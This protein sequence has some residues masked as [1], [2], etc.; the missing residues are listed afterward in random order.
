MTVI[1]DSPGAYSVAQIAL[2][3]GAVGS[4]AIAVDAA[5]PLPVT[6]SSAPLPAGAATAANQ[7]TGNTSL[8]SIDTRL[9]GTVSTDTVVRASATDR[10]AV[11][12]TANTAQQLMAANSARRG[13]AIQN[14]SSGDCYISG[15]GTAT[16]DYHSLKIPSGGYYES[17]STHVGTGAISIICTVANASI[18]AREW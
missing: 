9:A 17:P 6:Q 15:Q 13:I 4:S 14:Q 5:H 16:A 10:G 3:Y 1:V 7:T 8:A 18:Y 12:A 11:V 2:A